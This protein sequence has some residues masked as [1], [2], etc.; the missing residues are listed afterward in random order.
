MGVQNL[1]AAIKEAILNLWAECF[2]RAR[3]RAAGNMLITRVLLMRE[4]RSCVPVPALAH[5]LARAR[6][7]P[8]YVQL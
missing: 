4:W 7:L 6:S 3:E 1:I 5:S 8:I 2:C